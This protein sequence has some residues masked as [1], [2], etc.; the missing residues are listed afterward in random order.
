MDG[1]ELHYGDSEILEIRDFLHEPGKGTSFFR[2][3]ARTW[4][5]RK[6]LDVDF[7]DNEIVG[8]A[9]TGACTPVE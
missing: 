4:P 8:V 5:R 7:V 6:T 2:A 9:R 3:D 1:K